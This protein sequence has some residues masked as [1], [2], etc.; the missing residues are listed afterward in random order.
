MLEEKKHLKA[1]IKTTRV[2]AYLEAYKAVGK[3]IKKKAKKE[4]GFISLLA[5]ISLKSPLVQQELSQ[6]QHKDQEK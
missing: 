4:K 1:N 6:E 3:K 2:E 5:D